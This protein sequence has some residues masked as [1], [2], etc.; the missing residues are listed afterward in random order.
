MA[1]YIIDIEMHDRSGAGGSRD[2]NRG[3]GKRRTS[4]NA[5]LEDASVVRP[6]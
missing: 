1:A 6:P 3:K 2:A 4:V 5:Q